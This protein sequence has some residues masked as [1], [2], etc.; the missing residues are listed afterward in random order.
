MAL[1]RLATLAVDIIVNA[2]RA[3]RQLTV[4][5]Y[6]FE[7]LKKSGSGTIQILNQLGGLLA[8]ATAVRSVQ[9]LVTTIMAVN[10]EAAKLQKQIGDIDKIAG[11]GFSKATK[12]FFEFDEANPS[13]TFKEISEAM[14]EAARAGNKT[15]ESISAIAQAGIRLSA[16]SGDITSGRATK[17]LARFASNMGISIDK[18]DNLASSI[19]ILSDNYTTTSGEILS[20]STRMTGFAQTVGL[21]QQQLLGFTA[22]L[23]SAGASATTLRT[24][25]TKVLLEIT[26]N[27]SAVAKSVGLTGE[28]W[29]KFVRKAASNP[30]EAMQIFIEKLSSLPIREQTK[31]LKDLGLNSSR[32]R[33]IIEL[34]KN[35][36]DKIKDAVKLASDEYTTGTALINKYNKE[37]NLQATALTKLE[38]SWTKFIAGLANS[39]LTGILDRSIKGTSKVIEVLFG[40]TNTVQI[41]TTFKVTDL[42]DARNKVKK[43]TAELGELGTLRQKLGTSSLPSGFLAFD[44]DLVFRTNQ[45]SKVNQ[46]IEVTKIKLQ[47]AFELFK[48]FAEAKQTKEQAE[49]DA[50]DNA[51][52]I[53]A[54]ERDKLKEELRVLEEE[55]DKARATLKG[56]LA[57]AKGPTSEENI[58][59]NFRKFRN[60]VIAAGFEVKEAAGFI[61]KAW[62]IA[63]KKIKDAAD[64]AKKLIADKASKELATNLS[65]AANMAG[66]F[67]RVISSI[68]SFN[69]QKAGLKKLLPGF[70]FSRL[71]SL[72]LGDLGKAKERKVQFRGLTQAYKDA[73]KTTDTSANALRMKQLELAKQLVKK[74][75]DD[76]VIQKDAL[77]SLKGIENNIGIK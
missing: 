69:S 31:A 7:R 61:S 47:K 46:E 35:S 71:L 13:A 75:T 29:D 66:N 58:L 74:V 6:H 22:V 14:Q 63:Q 34:M 19:D 38:K 67:G 43:L 39:N 50:Q 45:I 60:E 11:L 25:L 16:T 42:E 17:N 52:A 21:T 2:G 3:Q 9:L 15:A 37:I 48:A 28:A 30:F 55:R 59:N 4:T 41:P 51:G 27:T 57:L 1:D 10:R 70:D 44:F 77:D 5:A 49:I 73:F 68:T 33:Q 62:V 12:A 56:K 26:G 23:N 65:N 8:F 76:A 72:Q 24:T 36:M 32:V 18:V 54:K 40:K 53:A 64:K 20:A